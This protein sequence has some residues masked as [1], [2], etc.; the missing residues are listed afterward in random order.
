MKR[1]SSKEE[2]LARTTHF[3]DLLGNPER[4]F[5]VVHVAGTAGK[6]STA[7]LIAHMLHADHRSV[8]LLTSPFVTTT[9]ENI[10]INGKLCN[11]EMFIRITHQALDVVDTLDN[12][13]KPSYAEILFAIGVLCA[14]ENKC[15]WLV[16]EVGCGGRFDYTNVF[17]QPTLCVLTP[18]DYDHT[19]IL[20]ETIPEI[21][22][23]K[24]GI[25]HNGC[26]VISSV[27][28]PE[29]HEVFDR[30]AEQ[31]NL[32]IRYIDDSTRGH[33]TKTTGMSG[34]HQ[35]RN[36]ELASLAAQALNLSKH[37][38]H[39]GKKYAKLPARCE[40]MQRDP[41]VIIDGAHSPIKIQALAQYLRTECTYEKLYIIY[42]AKETKDPEKNISPLVPLSSAIW[43]TE[44]HLPGFG[45]HSA[46]E[47]KKSIALHHPDSTLY[48]E[49]DPNTAF[50]QALATATERDCILI[51]GSL[52]LAGI[53]RDR[54]ISEEQ[55]VSRREVFA[56][57]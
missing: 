23:H 35:H 22:W 25:I 10:W 36:Q 52:Y 55:I 49:S 42:S 47:M 4:Q 19:N 57:E 1:G 26:T 53:L 50:T 46:E 8:G 30:E 38:I 16:V 6:G 13:T 43:C 12:A 40:I 56:Q 14:A 41:L 34:E 7:S 21:A 33:D 2:C 54:F 45:S 24:A 3:F 17:V 44:F 27:Q 51:T 28:N 37:A 9:L 31:H 39:E 29:V 32:S 11:P 48:A 18:I 15:E 20:G 5:Q